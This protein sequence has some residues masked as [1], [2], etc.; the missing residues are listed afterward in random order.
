[1]SEA[2][3][4]DCHD[5][6]SVL[7]HARRRLTCGIEWPLPA[8]ASIRDKE[9]RAHGDAR[10]AVWRHWTDRLRDIA[11]VP[12][13]QGEVPDIAVPEEHRRGEVTG[14][15]ILFGHHW[16]SGTPRVETP[17]IACLDW[18]AGATGPLVAYRWDGEQTLDDTKFVAF[19]GETP[20]PRARRTSEAVA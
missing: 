13:G 10:L 3:L 17:K 11:L 1:M 12:P 7:Y 20:E 4:R 5:P 2:F 14:T 15:P 9:G 8:G 19:G 6:D 18:S 16:F